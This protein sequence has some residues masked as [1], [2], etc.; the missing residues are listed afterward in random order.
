MY[1]ILSEIELGNKKY[2]PTQTKKTARIYLFLFF[3][4]KRN[5]RYPHCKLSSS[6]HFEFRYNDYFSK[7]NKR[8]LVKEKIIVK[9]KNI[10]LNR[11]NVFKIKEKNKK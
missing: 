6:K 8:N 4:A 9:G 1:C 7:N 11:L 3:K 5:S 10:I 2:P